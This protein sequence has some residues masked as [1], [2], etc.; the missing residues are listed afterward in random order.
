MTPPDRQPA[1][2]WLRYAA[3]S[4]DAVCLL[5]PLLLLGLPLLCAAL[6]QAKDAIQALSAD[7]TTL[8]ETAVTQGQTPF[9]MAL[10]M[11]SDPHMTSAVDRLS[12]AL[13][14]LALVPPLLYALLACL[15]SVGFESS[16]W[17]ATPGKRAFGLVVG[18][19]R[20]ERL[21]PL[22]TLTRF[23]AAGLSWLTLN[24]GHAMAAFKPHLALHD[25][26][27]HTRVLVEPEHAALPLW[28]RAWLLAQALAL[29]IGIAWGFVALQR[30][31]QGLMEQALSGI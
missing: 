21:R 11:L 3:W 31:M 4:L 24:F 20:G 15:W 30:W 1:G 27:S 18:N 10:S 23:A 14:S 8:L 19:E 25:R 29:V 17:Q 9:A 5:P 12:S 26:L 22:P 7:M 16:G 13:T 6:A 28:G 2:F